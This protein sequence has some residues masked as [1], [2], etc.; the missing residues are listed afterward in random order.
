LK[1]S[2]KPYF[3]AGIFLADIR[4]IILPY[5]D[6]FRG[7]AV[8][9]HEIAASLMAHCSIDVSDDVISILTAARVRVR[10]FAPHTTQ[11]FQV[12]DLTL[13]GALKRCPIY[14]R[15]FDEY[16]ATVKVITN[17]MTTSCKQWRGPMSGEHLVRLDLSLTGG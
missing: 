11:A 13:F 12:L 15:S 9:A 5:N 8:L 4:T 10:T 6:T 17:Y 1:F 3:N 16:N 2:Q 7:R 14:E